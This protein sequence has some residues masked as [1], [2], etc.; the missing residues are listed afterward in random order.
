[1][2]IKDIHRVTLFMFP[3]GLR[4][5]IANEME[6][7]CEKKLTLSDRHA[8]MRLVAGDLVQIEQGC[9]VFCYVGT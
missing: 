6:L 1:M 2:I 5:M 3:P 7:L 9:K 8:G 4:D